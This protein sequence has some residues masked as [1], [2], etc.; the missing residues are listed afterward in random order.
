MLPQSSKIET[1]FKK[2]GFNFH[3]DS[4]KMYTNT[5]QNKSMVRDQIYE[6]SKYAENSSY[7]LYSDKNGISYS[8]ELMKGNLKMISIFNGTPNKFV[9][10]IIKN[11]DNGEFL[12]ITI[13][14]DCKNEEYIYND[15]ESA[16]IKFKEIFSEKTDNNWDEVK[17]DHT[18]FCNNY[19]RSYVFCFSTKEEELMF[20]FIEDN[21][22][23]VLDETKINN[24]CHSD[25]FTRNLISYLLNRTFTIKVKNIST[26]IKHDI[27][28]KHFKN[29]SVK[30]TNSEITKEHSI[31]TY[32]NDYKIYSITSANEILEEIKILL[33]KE[34]SEYNIKKMNYLIKCFNEIIPFSNINLHDFNSCIDIDKEISRLTTYFMLE[35][36]FQ[37]FLAILYNKND[38]NPIDYVIKSLGIEIEKIQISING[39]NLT[40]ESDYIYD[41]IIKTG[42]REIKDR[43]ITIYKIKKTKN[44]EYFDLEN[45]QQRIIL[46]HGTRIENVLGILSQGLKISPIQSKN[47]GDKLGRGIYL[48]NS[49]GFALNYCFS[50]N[51]KNGTKE[52]NKDYVLLVETAINSKNYKL[53]NK[54]KCI[55]TIFTSVEGYKIIDPKDIKI[56]DK[57]I[58]LIEKETNVRVRYLV[59]IG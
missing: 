59:E 26:K 20:H 58:V 25:Y 9:M 13:D 56:N 32:L 37:L 24:N 31:K 18:K 28:L 7:E 5:I 16:E 23:S 41:Y 48:S 49:F 15:L 3:E 44:D 29:S 34:K 11:K 10:Q 35:N 36:T 47:Q 19:I 38:V 50:N 17:N 40:T 4:K 55:K 21:M 53:S 30:I 2:T 45:S 42:Y 8:V 6:K 46:S 57:G 52:N 54:A 12:V 1:K 14:K 33:Q 22:Q 43:N 39:G 27:Y 51:I